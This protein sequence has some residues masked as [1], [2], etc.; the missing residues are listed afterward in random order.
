MSWADILPVTTCF[1]TSNAL[2]RLCFTGL[3]WGSAYH[4]S[5]DHVIFQVSINSRILL[6]EPFQTTEALVQPNAW[7][8]VR[9]CRDRRECSSCRLTVL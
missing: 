7:S 4:T 3:L 8:V 2:A 5:P 1:R 6:V 9:Q